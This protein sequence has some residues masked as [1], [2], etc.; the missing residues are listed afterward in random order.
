MLYE[1]ITPDLRSL[2]SWRGNVLVA[3][4]EKGEDLAIMPLNGEFVSGN[5]YEDYDEESY[6]SL[7]RKYGHIHAWGTTAQGVYRAGDTIQY[8]LYLRNQDNRTFVPP[9]QAKYRITSY[10]VCYTKLLR[11]PLTNSPFRGMSARSSPFSQRATRTFPRQELRLRRSGSNSSVP[12]R[13]T[14]PLSSLV[15]LA[16]TAGVAVRPGQLAR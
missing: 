8:K 6:S 5:A 3:R 13:T 4:C 16:R 10:N 1:V 12:G 7:R 2:N 9:P 15:P 11:L 14:R